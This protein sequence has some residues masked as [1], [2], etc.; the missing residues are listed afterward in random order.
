[1]ATEKLL[2]QGYTDVHNLGAMK[3]AGKRLGL[4]AVK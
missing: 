2:K 4:P 3:D 1:M